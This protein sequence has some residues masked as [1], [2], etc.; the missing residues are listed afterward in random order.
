MKLSSILLPAAAMADLMPRSNR[1]NLKKLIQVSVSSGDLEAKGVPNS[2][3]KALNTY[4]YS[5]EFVIQPDVP[6]NIVE[7]FQ[8]NTGRTE[9]EENCDAG[10]MD[11]TPLFG[12]GCWCFFGNINS[13]LGRGPPIDAYD[14]VCK[15][16]T[17]CYR[18]IH[19]DSENEDDECD[20]YNADYSSNG[21]S[22]GQGG[23]SNITVT[24]QNENVPSCSWRTCSCAMTMVRRFFNLSFDPE[25]VYDTNLKHE[26]GFDYDLECPIQG[27]SK[28]RQCCGF[29]PNRRTFE[30]S[31][32]RQCCHEESI[33]NPL[34][35]QCCDDGTHIG[36]GN[37]C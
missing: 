16:L 8:I 25:N 18:C 5:N 35:H 19:V 27:V 26:N 1:E 10:I 30:R 9:C 32:Y 14:Q 7:W 29:Y 12:Y 2:I 23:I 31:E 28:D 11:M 34:R 21:F 24:C 15:D 6:K 20:P 36:I 17:L 4:V 37:E 33:Y 13:K 3:I 22:F